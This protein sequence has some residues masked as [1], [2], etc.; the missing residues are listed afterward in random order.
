M[1][2][3]K[4]DLKKWTLVQAYKHD[5]SMHRQWSP[6]YLLEEN[7]D[8]FIICSRS[9]L[10][11]ENDGR[12]WLTKENAVFILFKKEWLNVIC[13]FKE[14]GG[15]CYYANMASPT[16]MDDGFL[17]YI[18]YDL[19][20]K[21]YPDKSI[22]VLDELEFEANSKEYGYSPELIKVV[23]HSLDKTRKMMEE[24]KF[25]F[26]DQTIEDIYASFLKDT[27]PFLPKESYEKH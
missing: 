20:L 25:P 2:D 1:N 23:R 9:S 10:I 3:K 8:Y 18:D 15:I 14:S 16:I 11:T 17:R 7:D 6:G 19:D 22:K 5:G 13:M 24:R 21:L 27:I 4:N 26:N 12:R